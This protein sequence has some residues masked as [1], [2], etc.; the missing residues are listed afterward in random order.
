[1]IVASKTRVALLDKQTIPRLELLSNLAA[2]RLVKSMSQALENVVNV[3]DAVNWTDSMISLCWIRNTDKEYKQFVGN[4]VS[5][6]RRNALPE[7][8]RY[9]PTLENP[10]DITSRGIKA[11]ALKESSLWLH[12][13]EFLSKESIYWPVQPVN[14]QSKEKFCELKSAKP[15]VSSL[16]NPCTEKQEANLESIINPESYSS[17]TKLLHLYCY[18]SK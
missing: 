6:K 12:G 7:Q 18:L 8:W 16:L 10:A 5:E 13:P 15:T 2:S 9:C 11:T 17:L 1:M 4:R 14:V 3:D